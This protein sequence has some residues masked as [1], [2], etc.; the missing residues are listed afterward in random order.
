MVDRGRKCY[1][2]GW[3]CNHHSDCLGV[4]VP[5]GLLPDPMVDRPGTGGLRSRAMY[6]AFDLEYTARGQVLR[7]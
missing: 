3:L 7:L 6:H 1:P 2:Y 4:L 5:V